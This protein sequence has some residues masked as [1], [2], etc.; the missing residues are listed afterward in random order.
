M[1]N[2]FEKM[3]ELWWRRKQKITGELQNVVINIVNIIKGSVI[4]SSPPP[5]P[6]LVLHLN[7]NEEKILFCFLSVKSVSTAKI[8][9]RL[10]RR[11]TT[12]VNYQFADKIKLGN[13]Y[14]FCLDDGSKLTTVNP[15]FK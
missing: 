4:P 15:L 7:D 13:L 9:A 10:F 2:I 11:V 14:H 12:I 5:H 1:E 3:V 8:L 6:H